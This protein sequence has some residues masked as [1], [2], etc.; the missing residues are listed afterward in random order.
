MRL[1]ICCWCY[2]RRRLRA[3]ARSNCFGIH[4]PN[5]RAA[6]TG[7]ATSAGAG[8]LWQAAGRPPTEGF[9]VRRLPRCHPPHR[10]GHVVDS[11][12]V[13]A[14][15]RHARTGGKTPDL[16]LA[17]RVGDRR[18]LGLH[19]GRR[20]GSRHLPRRGRRLHQWLV[21]RRADP[22]GSSRRPD[23]RNRSRAEQAR[24]DYANRSRS[25]SVIAPGHTRRG[26]EPGGRCH[27]RRARPSR[28]SRS[29][30][31]RTLQ[32]RQLGTRLRGSSLG[33]RS[34]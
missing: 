8:E 16:G 33:P 29:R 4:T 13:A 32:P 20:R 12:L 17:G 31:R 2:P 28:C 22:C 34:A 30:A 1:S 27:A 3:Q 21:L 11:A 24:A 9:G 18:P 25:D 10:R 23:D 6:R 19:E 26:A 5:Q 15:R 7:A 14:S